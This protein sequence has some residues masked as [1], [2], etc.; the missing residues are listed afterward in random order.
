MFAGTRQ[1]YGLRARG[2]VNEDALV[3]RN[4]DDQARWVLLVAV[5]NQIGIAVGGAKQRLLEGLGTPTGPEGNLAA[6]TGNRQSFPE[7]PETDTG[8]LARNLVADSDQHVQLRYLQY[9]RI[10]RHVRPVDP[11]EGRRILDVEADEV[12]P[13]IGRARRRG[14]AE[15]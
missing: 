3:Y 13:A 12:H 5:C 2:V 7:S 9:R 15:Q 14:R 1:P 6:I 4:V 10:D 8:I 11:A